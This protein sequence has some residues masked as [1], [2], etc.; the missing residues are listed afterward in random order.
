[1][2]SQVLYALLRCFTSVVMEKPPRTLVA[3]PRHVLVDG[4]V[5]PGSA[6]S[7]PGGPDDNTEGI[8]VGCA[9]AVL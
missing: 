5:M 8:H 6:A 1:M 9:G 7:S 3:A 2:L 4:V